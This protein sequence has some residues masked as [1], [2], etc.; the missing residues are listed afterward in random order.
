M[1]HAG[2]E[3]QLL[4][5]VLGCLR[6]QTGILIPFE[7]RHGRLQ[8]RR[9]ANMPEN[10]GQHGFVHGASLDDDEGLGA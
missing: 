2:Q 4:G 10:L 6:W 3:R 8:D 1:D 5:A 9:L 7:H